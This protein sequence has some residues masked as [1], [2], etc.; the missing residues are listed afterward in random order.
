MS[1]F[2]YLL[3][4]RLLVIY[5]IYHRLFFYLL[6][7][8]SIVILIVELRRYC[9]SHNHTVGKISSQQTVPTTSF[10]PPTSR[11]VFN[12]HNQPLQRLILFSRSI[13]LYN[14]GAEFIQEPEF[15]IVYIT[16]I[17][18]LNLTTHISLAMHQQEEEEEEHQQRERDLVKETPRPLPFKRKLTILLE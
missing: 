18:G 12:P 7:N 6:C 15:H 17:L 5:S 1:S 16:E 11:S 10:F 2:F 8:T 4:Q 9:G 13:H 14:V 3:F